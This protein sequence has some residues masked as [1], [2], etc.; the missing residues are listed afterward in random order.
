MK[1]FLLFALVV[2]ISVVAG[3]ASAEDFGG[4]TVVIPVAMHGPGNLD[5]VWVTDVWIANHSSVAKTVTMDFYP[6]TGGLLTSTVALGEYSNVTLEDV[7][8]DTFGLDN[9]KGMLILSVEGSSQFNAQARIYNTGNPVGE[10]GQFVPGFSLLDL[11]RQA[12]VYGLSGIGGN[13][14]NFGIANPTDLTLSVNVTLFDSNGD[15]V[16]GNVVALG[17]MQLV[18]INDIFAYFGVSPAAGMQLNMEQSSV[19]GVRI[20]GYASVVRDDTGDAI[21]LPGLAVNSGPH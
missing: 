7:V 6:T 13:R 19:E 14:T 9:A 5:T 20:Y 17:P 21:F 15:N 11:G 4:T 1:K 8:L 3:P 10:F 16:A 18:Q 12:F 2:A